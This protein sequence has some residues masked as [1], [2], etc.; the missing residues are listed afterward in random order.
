MR[1]IIFGSAAL[2]GMLFAPIADACCWSTASAAASP[3]RIQDAPCGWFTS[4][5][6]DAWGTDHKILMNLHVIVE[7]GSFGRGT[8]QLPDG[9][10]AY[11]FL[12]RKCGKD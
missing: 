11:E 6:P 1:N 5:Y 7:N 3:T 12:Q 8:F 10:D 4:V 2:A 9:T